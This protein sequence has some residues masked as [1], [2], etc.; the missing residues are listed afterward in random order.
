MTADRCANLL[1][2][3]ADTSRGGRGDGL[4]AGPR[5][6]GLGG[7]GRRRLNELRAGGGGAIHTMC[8]VGS[9]ACPMT[10]SAARGRS[11]EGHRLHPQRPAHE[12]RRGASPIDRTSRCGIA[13]RARRRPAARRTCGADWGGSAQ[14]SPRSACSSYT[15]LR[16]GRRRRFDSLSGTFS[17]NSQGDGSVRQGLRPTESHH[18]DDV[19]VDA[20]GYAAQAATHA[21]SR[22][23]VVFG[24]EIYDERI[25]ARREEHNP[26]TGLTEQR[27]ALY[28]NG[29]IYRT[30]GVF[31][32]DVIDLVPTPG[33]P[34]DTRRAS[35]DDSRTSASAPTPMRTGTRSGPSWGSLIRSRA[36][37][38]GRSPAA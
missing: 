38:T 2:A 18:R 25:D 20:F 32:Q 7:A 15:A 35:A 31:V 5:L 23:A 14:I 33:G 28:P 36:I 13:E 4:V 22:H 17:V 8:S 30:S 34:E 37:A 11:A 16:S 27:R 10:K 24:G 26:R 21:G 12:A 9:S 1:A 19:G 3:S 29:S 6:S